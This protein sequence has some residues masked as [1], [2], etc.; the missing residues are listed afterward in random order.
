[1]LHKREIGASH[2]ENVPSLV[3]TLKLSHYLH[4]DDLSACPFFSL[5]TRDLKNN[6]S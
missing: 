3:P 1:M 2:S 4:Q 5:F 6:K